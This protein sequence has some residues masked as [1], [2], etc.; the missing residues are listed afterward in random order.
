[1]G[2]SWQIILSFKLQKEVEGIFFF[3]RVGQKVIA[4]LLSLCPFS[5]PVKIFIRPLMCGLKSI[6]GKLLKI[7]SQLWLLSKY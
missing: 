2:Y 7:I 6:A 3:H 1:M 5:K 4:F